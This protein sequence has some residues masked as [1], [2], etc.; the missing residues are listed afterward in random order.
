MY[1]LTGEQSVV[2][3]CYKFVFVNDCFEIIFWEL[4]NLALH[5]FSESPLEHINRKL[6]TYCNTLK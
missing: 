4:G 5:S 1:A 6:I 2:G 3:Y